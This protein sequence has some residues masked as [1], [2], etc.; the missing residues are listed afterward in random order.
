MIIWELETTLLFRQLLSVN[1]VSHAS[2]YSILIVWSSVMLNEA[3]TS[4]PRLRPKYRGRGQSYEAEART[5]RSRPRPKIILKKVPNN[6]N[7]WFKII[8]G[9][10]LY[11]IPEFYTIFAR[12]KPDYIIRQDNKIEARPRPKPRGR[13]QNFGLQDL[14]SL[15]IISFNF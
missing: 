6:D 12:K 2:N 7:I 1:L 15:V 10:F 3:K 5:M 4:R 14:T 8:A 9:N 11:K 13:G